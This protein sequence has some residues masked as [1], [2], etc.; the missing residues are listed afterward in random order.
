MDPQ[1]IVYL[2]LAVIALVMIII[3]IFTGKH[4][5]GRL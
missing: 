3:S 5:V 4:P 1:L 2:S